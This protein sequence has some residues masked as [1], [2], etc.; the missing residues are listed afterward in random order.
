MHESNSE[1]EI[2]VVVFKLKKYINSMS[3]MNTAGNVA[4]VLSNTI[5][6]LCNQAI[7]KARAD[8]CKTV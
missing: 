7:Q 1:K 2:L 8:G 3:G 5:R 4:Q 6:S